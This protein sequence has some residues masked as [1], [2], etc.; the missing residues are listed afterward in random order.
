MSAL[1]ILVFGHIFMVFTVDPYAIM[2]MVTGRYNERF[3]PEARDARPF[4][5]LSPP[6]PDA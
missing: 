2:S 1:V 3:A 6:K 5:H 4:Y